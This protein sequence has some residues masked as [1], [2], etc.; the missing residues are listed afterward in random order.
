MEFVASSGLFAV[1]GAPCTAQSSKLVSLNVLFISGQ[2]NAQSNAVLP[3]SNR[4]VVLEAL[5]EAWQQF[6]KAGL[7]ND[8]VNA[9][10]SLHKACRMVATASQSACIP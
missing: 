2:T 8:V 3:C 5:Q 1:K 10:S 4:G 7:T 6:Y 9:V